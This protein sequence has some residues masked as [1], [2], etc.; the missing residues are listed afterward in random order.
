MTASTA[1]RVAWVL[2][3]LS[4]VLYLV[5]VVATLIAGH[6]FQGNDVFPLLI[7]FG[8]SAVGVL[9]AS[10]SARNA[11]G[12]IY[13]G[14]GLS[15]G[16]SSLANAGALIW[17]QGDGGMRRYGALAAA[18][19]SPAW[20]GWVLVPATFLLLLFPDGRLL[21]VRW[22]WVA[23][24]AGVGIGGD[25]VVGLLRKGEIEDWPGVINPIG[26]AMP[27][28][29]EGVT[30]LLSA[31]AIVASAIS[32]VVRF[33]RVSGLQRQQIKW[34][35]FAGA[36][37]APT[38]LFSVAAYDT[39]GSAAANTI[40]QIAVLAV[41]LAA[42][43][44]I[45]RYRLY[46]IDVVVNRT[47]VYGA[48]TATLAAAYLGSVLLLQFALQPLTERSELAVAGSTLA[49]AALFG[50]ARARIQG[51]VDRRFYRNRYDAS[52]I[53]A[54]FSGRLREEVDLQ[55]MTE[56][57]RAVVQETVQPAHLSVWMSPRGARP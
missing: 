54:A 52:R 55:A 51:V 9:I 34:L 40:I 18:I 48:L 1:R 27:G 31:I 46:D 50:P 21:S 33:R 38:V 15:A 17:L 8:F 20:I 36:I 30:T 57:L 3:A 13:C 14:V 45:L 49:V 26:V 2:A 44:A 37:A 12:W 6:A 47:L 7:I 42:G 4:G 29:T 25:F 22:R 24:C 53:L 10:S 28:A 32:L 41:P 56:D 16:M 11:I 35:A 43:I 23:W 39:L 5:A 19:A